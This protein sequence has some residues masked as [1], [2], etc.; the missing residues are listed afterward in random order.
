MNAAKWSRHPYSHSDPDD[1]RLEVGDR[2]R[3]SVGHLLGLCGPLCGLVSRNA[4]RTKRRIR[5]D[6]GG[7]VIAT[8]QLGGAAGFH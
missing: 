1:G 7:P 6:K 8:L 2:G 5:C 3:L 4:S